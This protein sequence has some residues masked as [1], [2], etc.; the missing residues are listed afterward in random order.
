MSANFVS[1]GGK[2]MGNFNP[3]Y[4]KLL[5]CMGFDYP[6]GEHQTDGYYIEYSGKVKRFNRICLLEYENAP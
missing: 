5:E 4:R 6:L 1:C 3:V 2:T